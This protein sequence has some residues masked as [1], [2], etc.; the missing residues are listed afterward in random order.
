MLAYTRNCLDK[1]EALR[2]G[3]SSDSELLELDCSALEA[4]ALRMDLGAGLMGESSDDLL[5]AGLKV[6]TLGP[7]ASAV[8][9]DPWTTG[10]DQ[11]N[12]FFGGKIAL[13]DGAL[14]PSSPDVLAADK[15]SGKNK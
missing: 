3:G 8:S 10:E 6:Q 13:L 5:S 1:F 9:G 12:R 4:L 2:L 11:R 7:A 15:S 14:W